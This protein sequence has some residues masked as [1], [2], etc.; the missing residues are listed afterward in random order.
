[1]LKNHPLARHFMDQ[2]GWIAGIFL[3]GA[4]VLGWLSFSE[5]RLGRA[6]DARGVTVE[7]TVTQKTRRRVERT[8]KP[9]R[10]ERVVTYVWTWNPP[11]DVPPV[12]QT[13]RR[14]VPERI[15]DRARKGRTVMLRHLPEDPTAVEVYPGEAAGKARIYGWIGL[16][17]LGFSAVVGGGVLRQARR[18]LRVET[19]G[20][21]RVGT[22]ISVGT[23]RTY[24]VTLSLG[25]DASAGR[26]VVLTGRRADGGTDA[27][28]DR[29]A[30]RIDP[31]D[32][33]FALRDPDAPL[34]ATG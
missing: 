2:G 29:I 30:I 4:L 33:S 7:A 31:D 8:G 27:V 1:M 9:D 10:I 15:Y 24:R 19:G 22:V 14:A 13:T 28:G 20:L 3:A 26:G 23:G 25:E 18:R 5:A 16:A 34:R 11:G 21:A 6:L 17:G 32:P 12:E